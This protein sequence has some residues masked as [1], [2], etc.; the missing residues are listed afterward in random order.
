MLNI[1]LTEEDIELLHQVTTTYNK[2]PFDS[3]SYKMYRLLQLLND[4]VSQPKLE[5]IEIKLTNASLDTLPS[6]TD[7]MFNILDN[8]EQGS[9]TYLNL[10]ST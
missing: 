1:Q 10:T 7:D 6:L 9:R 3:K 2:L 8:F 5:P 4:K